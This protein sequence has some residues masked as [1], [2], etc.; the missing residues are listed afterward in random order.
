MCVTPVVI[1]GCPR[2][3][4]TLLSQL[5]EPT[6][7][8][9]PVETHFVTKYFKMLPKFG[10]LSVRKN[11]DKLIGKILRERPV[12]Q[13]KL[14]VDLDALWGSLSNYEYREIVDRLLMLRFSQHGKTSWGEKTPH[15]TL[16]LDIL[17]SL[18]PDAK[19]L[20]IVRDGRDVALSLLK[21]PWGP[22]NIYACAELWKVYNRETP[23]LRSIL[24]SGKGLEVKYEDLITNTNAVTLGIYKFLEEEYRGAEMIPLKNGIMSSNYNKW[25]S[26][27]KTKQIE[28]F[29]TVAGSTLTR[30]GYEVSFPERAICPTVRWMC[31][32]HNQLKLYKNLAKMNTID[33]LRIKLLNMEPFAE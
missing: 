1:I 6:R 26:K 23:T 7:Y 4:T 14:K 15:Y 2:S 24:N 21:Q 30:L 3:G 13:W 5:L 16:E 31:T 29:E 25:K 33:A 32:A 10:D 22:G 27:L 20:Y 9:A 8:G 18:Y 12:M 28:I 11:F 17:Y 19:Y